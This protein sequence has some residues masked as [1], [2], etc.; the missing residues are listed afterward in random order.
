MVVYVDFAHSLI[1]GRANPTRVEPFRPAWS[2][3]DPHTEPAPPRANPA[4]AQTS[5]KASQAGPAGGAPSART[6]PS[7]RP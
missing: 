4:N 7:I 3:P 2:E 1:A 6:C 5:G